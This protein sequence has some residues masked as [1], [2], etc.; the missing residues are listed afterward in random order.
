LPLALSLAADRYADWARINP[1]ATAPAREDQIEQLFELYR[2]NRYPAIVRY[3]LFRR[4]YFAEA[5][6]AIRDAFESFLLELGRRQARSPFHMEE[7]SKLQA[8]L[9][10]PLDRDVFSRMLLPRSHPPQLEVI[11][12]GEGPEKQVVVQTEIQ[13][14]HGA[15][16]QVREPVSASEAGHL[17]RL[18]FESGQLAPGI[19][20][21]DRLVLALD[22]AEEIV[23]GIRYRPEG[24]N[25]AALQEL[26]VAHALRG[27]GIGTALLEDFCTRMTAQGTAVVRTQFILR[28]F[29]TAR[30]FR[31]DARWGGLVRMSNDE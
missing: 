16:Y 11:A 28:R 23:A 21:Q 7:L 31:P 13:D 29:Y 9:G 20:E 6:A 14:R 27:R 2:L 12:I 4:T 25:V 8:A 30:G 1:A 5:A 10:D 24:R 15:R 17:F 18:L 3:E 22:E 19:S 26:V